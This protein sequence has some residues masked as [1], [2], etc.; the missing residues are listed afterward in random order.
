VVSLAHYIA[1]DLVNIIGRTGIFENYSLD[2]LKA[3][4]FCQQAVMSK[5]GRHGPAEFAKMWTSGLSCE[6]ILQFTSA[7]MPRNEQ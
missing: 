1:D 3:Y 5:C 4:W 6:S 7:H 2:D